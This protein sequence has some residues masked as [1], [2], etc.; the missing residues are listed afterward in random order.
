[1]Y[2]NKSTAVHLNSL[3]SSRCLLNW[4][5]SWLFIHPQSPKKNI[6][7]LS[8]PSWLQPGGSRHDEYFKFNCLSCIMGRK[9]VLFLSCHVKLWVISQST[10]TKEAFQ[11]NFMPSI[12]ALWKKTPWN[13]VLVFVAFRHRKLHLCWAS[14]WSCW[15]PT[16]GLC[17]TLSPIS[18]FLCYCC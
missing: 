10:S 14:D 6:Y 12:W 15:P 17:C 3:Y 2:K 7:F 11:S 16:R 4:F 5:Y 1:M 18:V 9:N 8:L 13:V